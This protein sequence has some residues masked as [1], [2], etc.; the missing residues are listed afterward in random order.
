MRSKRYSALNNLHTPSHPPTLPPS[1]PPILSTTRFF[2]SVS[3][4]S[5]PP[6]HP[7]TH[8]STHRPTHHPSRSFA[9]FHAGG[10]KHHP[11]DRLR[12]G[13][14][15]YPTEY[16][17]SIEVMYVLTVDDKLGISGGS[18]Y[19]PALSIASDAELFA[20]VK[21]AQLERSGERDGKMRNNPSLSSR[22]LH[23]PPPPPPPFYHIWPLPL[24]LYL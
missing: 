17:S 18:N 19:L 21:A 14:D 3:V 5:P 6:P 23:P 15:A 7:P 8:L 13:T 12:L 1:R 2:L 4:Y 10:P 16:F 11:L 20:Q 9:K 22:P 24:F